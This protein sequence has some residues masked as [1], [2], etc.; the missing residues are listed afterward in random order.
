MKRQS[1]IPKSNNQVGS[2]QLNMIEQNNEDDTLKMSS[3]DKI[4]LPIFKPRLDDISV[5]FAKQ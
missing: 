4:A 2:L 1:Q 5:N 3:S